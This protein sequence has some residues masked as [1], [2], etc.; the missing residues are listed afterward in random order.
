ME[1]CCGVRAPLLTLQRPRRCVGHLTMHRRKRME[2]IIDR[3][4]LSGCATRIP[5]SLHAASHCTC[6]RMHGAYRLDRAACVGRACIYGSLCMQ[7]SLCMHGCSLRLMLGM[8]TNSSYMTLE[9]APLCITVSG[10]RV[11]VCDDASLERATHPLTYS[12]T[13]PCAPRI[14]HPHARPLL[15]TTRASKG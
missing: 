9:G 14:H 12:P 3:H 8:I 13:H 4:G 15:P 7:G 5:V 2:R 1:R 11:N 10:K 6:N